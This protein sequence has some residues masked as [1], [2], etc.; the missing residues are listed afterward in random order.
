MAVSAESK[1]L[2]QIEEKFLICRICSDR[3]KRAKILPC[4]HSFCE[5]CLDKAVEKTG[6]L[7]CPICRRSHGLQGG[8]VARLSTNFFVNELVE[9]FRKRETKTEESK[10]CDG[11]KQNEPFKHCVECGVDICSF[12][13]SA[14]QAFPFLKSHRL[15]SFEEYQN[16]QTKDPASVQPPVPCNKHPSHAVT[17]YCDTC[18]NPICLE[19]TALEHPRPGHNYRYLNDV[20]S[21]FTKELLKMVAK[22]NEKNQDTVDSK[23][24][25]QKILDSLDRRFKGEEKKVKDHADKI[26]K[27]VT[28]TIRQN[29]KLLLKELK[30]EYEGRKTNLKAQL[31]ELV[32]KENDLVNAREFA[33]K[34]MH[35][36]NAAQL[37]SAKR[38]MTYQIQELITSETKTEPIEHDYMSFQSVADYYKEKALG[39]IL[40]TPVTYGLKG[41]PQFTCIG[42]DMCVTMATTGTDNNRRLSQMTDITAMVKKP[43]NEREDMKVDIKEDGT[44]AMRCQTKIEGDHEIL[45]SVRQ[46]PVQGSPVKVKVIP[47]KGLVHKYGEKGKGVGQL[48]NPWGAALTKSGCVL[49]CD[50]GNNRLQMF[51]VKGNHKR[52]MQITDSGHTYCPRFV[53]VSPDG[54]IF[55]TNYDKRKVVVCDENGKVLRCFGNNE[56]QSPKGIVFSPTNKRVYVS[57]SSAHCIQ[58]YNQDGDHVK[59]FSS[60][61]SGKGQVNS[62]CCVTVDSQGNVV[63][64]DELNHR[65]QV[66][67]A[68]GE[69]L[70]SF[71]SQG[72]G[73]GQL[74]YPS[75]VVHDKHDNVY[76][77]EYSNNRVQKFNSRG[78]FI[79]RIDSAKDGLK[80]PFG[81]CVTDD[82]PFGKIVVADYGNHCIKVFAQIE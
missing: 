26:V 78:K 71:G 22:L 21:E 7:D 76:V 77:C 11:C 15:M 6:K 10:R 57:D 63:V 4:L 40:K 44:F 81:V 50:N 70:F 58:V 65:I 9:Q 45:V 67:N 52:A 27:E 72:I 30:D 64:S 5:Q 73:P 17:F 60:K 34:L 74:S 56:L 42:D 75:G 66:F 3:Y 32:N 18:D 19:C 46:K 2:D 38:G 49:V 23:A 79:C 33:D 41:V 13:T 80:N 55:F 53:S 37:M 31:K 62:P 82:E 29:E 8:G 59:S 47:K 43:D 24:A 68:E 16:K 20:A 39:T 28:Q 36:G 12:C 51:T 35:Y 54:K 25:V 61:G 14:H 48:N 69:H 1:F